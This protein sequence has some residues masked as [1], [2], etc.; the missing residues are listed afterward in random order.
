FI[1]GYILGILIWYLPKSD[2]NSRGVS[3]TLSFLVSTWGIVL[4]LSATSSTFLLSLIITGIGIVVS[5][6][7]WSSEI[8]HVFTQTFEAVLKAASYTI[9]AIKSFFGSY[10]RE[11]VTLIALGVMII[12]SLAYRFIGAENYDNPLPIILFMVGYGIGVVVWYIP[13]PHDS[14]RRVCTILSTVVSFWGIILGIITGNLLIVPLGL[15]S[16]GVIVN[17]LV[18]RT[19]LLQLSRLVKEKVE[20]I[21][22]EMVNSIIPLSLL[23]FAIPAILYAIFVLIYALVPSIGAPLDTF[24]IEYIPGIEFLAKIIQGG[25]YEGKLIGDLED[26]EPFM[27]L[28]FSTIIILLG[29]VL[30]VIVALRREGMQLN[31]LL[32]KS[33]SETKS[34][35]IKHTIDFSDKD[36]DDKK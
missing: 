24:L 4:L 25:I 18:W 8:K 28:I 6:V 19:E 36:G 16:L 3:T 35:S 32:N 15:I 5:I 34:S 20:I 10:Y 7:L 30:I 22:G 17:G 27:K 33:R 26:T 13:S 14:F 12:G 29:V 31:S 23:A 9:Q 2:A 21:V 11:M 1:S